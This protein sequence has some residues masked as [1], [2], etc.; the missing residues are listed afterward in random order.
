MIWFNEVKS[1]TIAKDNIQDAA[2][3]LRGRIRSVVEW[4]DVVHGSDDKQ[5]IELKTARGYIMIRLGDE[6]HVDNANYVRIV[7]KSGEIDLLGSMPKPKDHVR[8]RNRFEQ[9]Q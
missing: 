7:R 5:F 1:V 2:N 4:D 6:I 9:D 3:W 8:S